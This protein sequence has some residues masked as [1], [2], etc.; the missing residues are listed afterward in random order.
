MHASTRPL[1]ESHLL[2]DFADA[3]RPLMFARGDNVLVGAGEIAR[4]TFYGPDRFARAAEVWA[5]LSAGARREA[6]AESLT[7]LAGVGPIA[8]GSFSFADDSPA[9]STLIV[10]RWVWGRRDGVGFVTELRLDN[11]AVPAAMPTRTEVGAHARVDW[12]EPV[13]TEHYLESVIRA[14]ERISA[15]Q[16]DKVVLARAFS[17]RLADGADVRAALRRLRERFGSSWVFSVDGLVGAS[18]ETL[19]ATRAGQASLRVLAGT[20]DAAEGGAHTL[21]HSAKDQLEHRIALDNVLASLQRAGVSAEVPG[22]PYPLELPDLWHLASD[23]SLALPTGGIWAVL[24]AI[25]PT[26]AVAGTPTDTA[27]RLIAELE[28]NDRGRYAGPVG[29]IDADGNGEWALALRCLQL[30]DPV[31]AHAGGGIVASSESER[32]RRE[33]E[34]KWRSIRS[35]FID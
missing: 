25:C 26:A 11:E 6:H 28:P 23:V 12:H 31:R 19:I 1:A 30:G 16:L 33:T 24:E 32:E 21:L 29:W 34:L 2:L 27:L 18:P 15:G 4:Y 10:P 13:D 5:G 35:A 20:L 7:G 22:E 8:F 17:G 9:G 14:V 3:A